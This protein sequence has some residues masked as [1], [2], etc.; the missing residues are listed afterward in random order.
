MWHESP[1]FMK[2]KNSIHGV[3]CTHKCDIIITKVTI[4]CLK[5]KDTKDKKFEDGF[6]AILQKQALEILLSYS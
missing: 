6:C 5:P 3:V 1:A 2:Q 4:F